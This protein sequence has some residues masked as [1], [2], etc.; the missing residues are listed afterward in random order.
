MLWAVLQTLRE[1]GYH[2]VGA[3]I[4]EGNIP[5]EQL[6]GRMGFQKVSSM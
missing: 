1:Q 6:L 2:K 5:S 4:T 3:V